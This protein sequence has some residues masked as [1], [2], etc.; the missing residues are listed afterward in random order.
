MKI[1]KWLDDNFEKYI[2]IV[3]MSVMTFVIFL[4]F[5]MRRGFNNSLTWSE[6]LARYLFIWL[7]YIG[8]SYGA[9]MKSH[10]KLEAFIVKLPIKIQPSFVLFAEV[11]FLAFAMFIV[12]TSWGVVLR[13]VALGQT[14]PAIGIP[15]SVVYAAPTV[16]FA[17]ASIRQVQVIIQ[18]VKEM[19]PKKDDNQVS[20]TVEEGK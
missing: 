1:L 20:E 7:I 15:M 6:E 4:Q 5:V 3:L 17:L 13:Q 8:I 18:R 16:G 19:R 9:K 14:S 11:L 10:I 2:C 12:Y